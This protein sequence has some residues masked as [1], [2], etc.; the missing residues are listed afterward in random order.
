MKVIISSICFLGIFVL[1]FTGCDNSDNVLGPQSNTEKKPYFGYKGDLV[2]GQTTKI[3]EFTVSSDGT[4]LTINYT[5]TD[6]K[7]YITKTHLYVGLNK[8]TTSAPGQFPYKH[9]NIGYTQSDAFT[10][11]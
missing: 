3:G 9:E 1:L 8:P 6:S 2:A 10:I 4:D 11:S 7:W 5:I